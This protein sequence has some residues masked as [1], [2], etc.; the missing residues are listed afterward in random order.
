MQVICDLKSP[1][2]FR[3]PPSNLINFIS[4]HDKKIVSAYFKP[5]NK[6]FLALTSVSFVS[7]INLSDIEEFIEREKDLQLT[8]SRKIII[9]PGRKFT[10]VPELYYEKDIEKQI[11]ELNFQLNSN[12]L[13]YRDLLALLKSYL[14]YTMTEEE[15]AAID[16]FDS[17]A[18]IHSFIPLFRTS[19]LNIQEVMT[20][21]LIL[22]IESNFIIILVFNYEKK[23]LLANSFPYVTESDI[24]YHVLNV[25]KQISLNPDRDN[26]LI[27]GEYYPDTELFRQIFKYIRY[28]LTHRIPGIIRF[29]EIFHD[30]PAHNYFNVLA[31]ALCV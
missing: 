15:K 29:H 13:I 14:L 20:N 6:T 11:F 10:L 22:H 23:L 31:A 9:Y 12:E 19:V 5:D 18:V 24:L 26:F 28:P 25:C 3:H 7:G 27:S 16:L 1:E 17:Q 4:I 30:F 8:G 21:S 2:L